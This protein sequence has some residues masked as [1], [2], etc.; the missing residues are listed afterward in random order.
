MASI[1]R[2]AQPET[3]E[4]TT[5]TRESQRHEAEERP[6]LDLLL[7]ALKDERALMRRRLR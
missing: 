6:F 7:K 4:L 3:R 1:F 5:W 2:L